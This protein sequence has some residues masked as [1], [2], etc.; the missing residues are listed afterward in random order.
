MDVINLLQKGIINP[1]LVLIKLYV[2]FSK[3]FYFSKIRFITVSGS[4]KI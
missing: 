4:V 1:K 3:I 2:F